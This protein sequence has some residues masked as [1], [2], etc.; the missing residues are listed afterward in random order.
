MGWRWDRWEHEDG[1]G[2]EVNRHGMGMEMVR[3]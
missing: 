2:I 1:D 3:A